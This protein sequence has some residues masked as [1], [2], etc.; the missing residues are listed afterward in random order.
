MQPLATTTDQAS[1]GGGPGKD[2]AEFKTSADLPTMP[3]EAMYS[4]FF[5]SLIQSFRSSPFDHGT[6]NAEFWCCDYPD[7]SYV[8]CANEYEAHQW[9]LSE[10]FVYDSESCCGACSDWQCDNSGW[11]ADCDYYR[12]CHPDTPYYCSKDDNCYYAPNIGACSPPPINL[13]WGSISNTNLWTLDPAGTQLNDIFKSTLDLSSRDFDDKTMRMSSFTSYNDPLKMV[14]NIQNPVPGAVYYV[15][16]RMKG[17]VWTGVGDSTFFNSKGYSK[18]Y[19]KAFKFYGWS[20]NIPE[21]YT[22]STYPIKLQFAKDSVYTYMYIDEI[23][24]IPDL[25]PTKECDFGCT[26]SVCDDPT[27]SDGILNQG[28]SDIDCGGSCE[29]CTIGKS[30]NFKVDCGSN[31]EC[32]QGVCDYSYTSRSSTIPQLLTAFTLQPGNS[33]YVGFD[34]YVKTLKSGEDAEITFSVEAASEGGV[35]TK[36]YKFTFRKE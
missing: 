32:I 18:Y 2:L 15:Y 11:V 1:Q 35:L 4:S 12:C 33:D 25:C 16:I 13:G 27:C 9:C 17:Q 20:F 21:G 5:L 29:G 6:C 7:C 14:L 3:Q 22:Q 26:N 10:G 24:L 31:M 30:C 23:L 8:A 19:N 34:V 36:D 28:E